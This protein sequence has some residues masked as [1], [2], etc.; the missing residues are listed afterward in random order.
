MTKELQADRIPDISD[1][2][3][4]VNYIQFQLSQVEGELSK[5]HGT[6][7]SPIHFKHLAEWKQS[8]V[9]ELHAVRKA[10]KRK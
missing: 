2:E 9:S 5:F 3:R 4:T 7:V 10:N 1:F 6:N 8:L